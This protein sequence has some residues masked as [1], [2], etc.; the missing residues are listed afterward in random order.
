M[1]DSRPQRTCFGCG[2]KAPKETL[3]RLAIERDGRITFDESQRA[4]GRGLYICAQAECFGRA[5]RK[6][7]PQTVTRRCTGAALTEAIN[8]AAT[9]LG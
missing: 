5:A 6:K 4:E 9:R 3:L 8:E 2:R 1:R 7:P